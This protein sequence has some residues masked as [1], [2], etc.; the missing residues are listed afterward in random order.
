MAASPHQLA[1]A[2]I[3]LLAQ[4]TGSVDN[5]Q[6]SD[7]DTQIGSQHDDTLQDSQEDVSLDD[8]EELKTHCNLLG[9][10]CEDPDRQHWYALTGAQRQDLLDQ[11]HR[12]VQRCITGSKAW[13]YGMQATGVVDILY[14]DHVDAWKQD[15]DENIA[16]EL[17]SDAPNS[18]LYQHNK[19]DLQQHIQDGTDIYEGFMDGETFTNFLARDVSPFSDCRNI[20][21]SSISATTSEPPLLTSTTELVS[22]IHTVHGS[23]SPVDQDDHTDSVHFEETEPAT[24]QGVK[25]ARTTSQAKASTKKRKHDPVDEEESQPDFTHVIVNPDH[26][27]RAKLTVID[28]EAESIMTR[29]RSCRRKKCRGSNDIGWNKQDIARELPDQFRTAD[30]E[31][32]YLKIDSH[33]RK[34]T[35]EALGLTD[36]Q[37]TQIAGKLEA[38]ERHINYKDNPAMFNTAGGVRKRQQTQA[39]H[40]HN[41][42]SG[43]FTKKTVIVN[44]QRPFDNIK[45]FT[46]QAIIDV[47][48]TWSTE[49]EELYKG[50][51]IGDG[52]KRRVGKAQRIAFEQFQLITTWMSNVITTNEE[53]RKHFAYVIRKYEALLTG[54]TRRIDDLWKEYKS[55]YDLAVRHGAAPATSLDELD[56]EIHQHIPQSKRVPQGLDRTKLA[57]IAPK[58]FP[59]LEKSSIDSDDE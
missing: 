23:E 50:I 42:A 6:D 5:M 22:S 59:T 4:A 3:N 41:E 54:H 38:K 18:V 44:P 12:L 46:P 40:P 53:N 7:D 45:D 10:Y 26:D 11:Y 15:F 31:H 13:K 51:D 49:L 56:K 16:P 32:I 36:A 24:K 47:A 57:G 20:E 2:A 33:L 30:K 27:S 28:A 55:L 8:A 37:W 58:M 29:I 21:D 17:Q 9:K 25:K 35:P 52:K 43:K 39:H 34:F 19:L 48:N 14:Q 1:R